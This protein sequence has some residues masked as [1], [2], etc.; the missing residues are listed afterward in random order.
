M[1]PLIK[2]IC[3]DFDAV[4]HT[5]KGWKG[6]E[7]FDP[8]IDNAREYMEKLKTDGWRIIIFTTRGNNNLVRYYLNKHEIPFDYISYPVM[9]TLLADS[10][11]NRVP[12]REV[13]DNTKYQSRSDDGGYYG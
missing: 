12:F 4:L 13:F 1:P 11:V 8:P 9:A 7:E 5:Y 10:L 2:T 6:E 3:V